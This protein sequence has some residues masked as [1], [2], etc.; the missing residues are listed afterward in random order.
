VTAA[1]GDFA[2]SNGLE[3]SVVDALRKDAA[4]TLSF[5]AVD[6]SAIVG[7]VAFSPARIVNG[8][9]AWFG[10]APVAVA[11]AHRRR[12]IADQLIRTGLETLR[13]RG[14]AGCVVLGDPA[15]PAYYARFGF[16]PDPA[17]FVAGVP[18]PFV[19][20][21]CFHGEPPRGEVRYHPALS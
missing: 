1:F 17:L 16:E 6:G 20:R 5:V 3:A 15:Y 18:A 21:L 4:L 8:P 9:P 10:L 13:T 7:H 19:Q 2:D 12:G 11:R 14:A